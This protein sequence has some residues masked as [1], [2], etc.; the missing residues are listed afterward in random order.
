M[1]LSRV[2][3]KFIHKPL[4]NIYRIYMIFINSMNFSRI[5]KKGEELPKSGMDTIEWIGPNA[6]EDAEKIVFDFN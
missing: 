1:V 3:T 5:Y 2:Y 4:G 6:P